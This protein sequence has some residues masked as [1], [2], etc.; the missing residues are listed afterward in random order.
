MHDLVTLQARQLRWIFKDS[1]LTQPPSSYLESTSSFR[2]VL[3][4]HSHV[5]ISRDTNHIQPSLALS[6]PA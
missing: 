1:A 4:T 2:G 5:P 6:G 3:H